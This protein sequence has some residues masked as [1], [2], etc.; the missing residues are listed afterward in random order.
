MLVYTMSTSPSVG[1]TRGTAILSHNN[2]LGLG[3]RALAEVGISEGVEDYN[4]SYAL[5]VNA[6]N[7]TLNF[8]YEN[9]NSRIIEQPFAPLDINGET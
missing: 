6:R 5:S 2:L 9:G 1:S 4:I 7:G 3:D 8:R